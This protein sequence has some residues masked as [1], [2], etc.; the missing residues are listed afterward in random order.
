M[1]VSL[2]PANGLAG[3]SSSRLKDILHIFKWKENRTHTKVLNEW[4]CYA[5]FLKIGWI[6]RET[7]KGSFRSE[8]LY[9]RFFWEVKGCL[10]IF[11]IG[12]IQNGIF[13]SMFIP[14]W[15]HTTQQHNVTWYVSTIVPLLLVVCIDCLCKA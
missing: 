10:E 9:S 6:F 3:P 14:I 13:M 12:E 8:N 5:C 1:W 2:S 4:Y 15:T 7:W 11:K